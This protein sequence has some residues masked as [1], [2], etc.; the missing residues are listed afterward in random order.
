MKRRVIAPLVLTCVLLI[1]SSAWAQ[2]SIEY[3]G[4]AEWDEQTA[5]LTFRTSGS[6]PD[7]REGFF[8]R[9]PARVKRIVIDEN[10]KMSGGF[11]VLYR[12]KENPLYIVGKDRQTSVIFGT[13]EDAWTDRNGIAENEKWKYSSISVIEDA[14]VHVSNIT[15]LNPRGYIISGYAHDAVIHVDSCSLL[16]TRTGNNNNSDGFAGAGGSSVRNS[17]I[18]TADDGIKIYHDIAIENTTIEQHRNGAPLQFGWGGEAETVSAQIK[19]LVIRG[20]DREN[21][22]NMAP[23]TWERGKNSVCNV[24]IDGLEVS[25]KGEVFNEEEMEWRPIGLFELKPSDCE[26]NLEVNSAKL[27]GLPLGLRKTK[28]TIEISEDGRQR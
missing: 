24:L 7:S 20:V 12:D 3:S 16:D 9:V 27:N 22:Y 5:T 23:M 11:R 15:C 17:L 14:V 8:L 2:M 10:V 25:I 4:E 26:F 18:S 19:G 13:D 28:G 21:R 6:M 1:Q